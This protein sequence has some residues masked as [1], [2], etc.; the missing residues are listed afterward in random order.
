MQIDFEAFAHY[1]ETTFDYDADFEDDAFALTFQGTRIYVER[2][3]QCFVIEVQSARYE[4]P[5]H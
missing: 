3:R 1:A 4:L 2:H 5:R